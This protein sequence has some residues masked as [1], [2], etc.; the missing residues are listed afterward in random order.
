MVRGMEPE[1][2]REHQRAPQ[3]AA[4]TRER[5]PEVPAALRVASAVG[6]QGFATLAREGA[7]LLPGGRVHPDVES[8]LAHT[9]GGGTPLEPAARERYGIGLGDSLHDVRLH[10]DDTADALSSAVSARA[11]TVGSDVYFGRGEYRPGSSDGDRLLAH[12]LTHVAQARGAPSD[13]PLQ[14]S[15]PGDAH[16]TEA[17]A[18]SRDLAG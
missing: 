13:G 5:E 1:A 16:E 3:R 9:R 2:Q 6:N 14:V 17:T 4:P 10:T 11:F 12:E 18:A 15:Q 7:G 8:T